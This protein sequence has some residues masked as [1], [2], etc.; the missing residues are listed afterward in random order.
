MLIS[1]DGDLLHRVLDL[2][3]VDPVAG[4]AARIVAG[5]Q[6]EALPEQ[7]GHQQAAVHLL[8]HAA[9]IVRAGLY[10]LILVAPRAA[11]GLQPE[12]ACRI[13]GSRR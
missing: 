3:V 8:Q 9:E 12:L 1:S 10:D 11:G 13:R 5:D 6:V 2:A 4:R 7:F